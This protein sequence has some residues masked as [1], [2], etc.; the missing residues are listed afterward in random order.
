MVSVFS[1]IY[2]YIYIYIY[3]HLPYFPLFALAASIKPRS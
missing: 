2:I 3:L 1:T